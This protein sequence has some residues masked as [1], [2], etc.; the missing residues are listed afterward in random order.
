VTRKQKPNK[1]RFRKVG[2]YARSSY[3]PTGYGTAVF[4]PGGYRLASKPPHRR[5]VLHM[6]AVVSGPATTR[7]GGSTLYAR[8]YRKAAMKA[9]YNSPRY[10]YATTKAAVIRTSQGPVAGMLKP[11]RVLIQRNRKG[12]VAKV[13][14]KPAGKYGVW[15]GERITNASF[16]SAPGEYR[17]KGAKH[18]QPKRATK[19]RDRSLAA[20]KAIRKRRRDSRGRLR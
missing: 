6:S 4:S 14:T 10:G 2:R 3:S 1:I 16:I 7:S 17:F 19:V 15:G 8:Q 13:F 9:K 5:T 18:K 11:Q 12:H 20:K